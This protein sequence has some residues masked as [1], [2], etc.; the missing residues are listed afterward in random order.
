MTLKLA[1]KH[2]YKDIIEPKEHIIMVNQ[3]KVAKAVLKHFNKH[4]M[5]C[6]DFKAMTLACAYIDEFEASPGLGLAE[7]LKIEI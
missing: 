2:T 1:R 3:N 4:E 5:G 6:S 7:Y